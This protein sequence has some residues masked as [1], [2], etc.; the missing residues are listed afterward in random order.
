MYGNERYIGEAIAEPVVP[1]EDVLLA[2]KTVYS[3]A[4]DSV[5]RVADAIDASLARLG[6]EYVDLLSVRWPVDVYEHETVLPQ[7][8]RAVRDGPFGRGV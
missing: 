4:P 6:V 3:D 8:E 7:Y 2:M 1:R 5:V